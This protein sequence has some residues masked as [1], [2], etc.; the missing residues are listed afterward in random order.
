LIESQLKQIVTLQ[1]DVESSRSAN[2]FSPVEPENKKDQIIR[3]LRTTN[4][5]LLAERRQLMETVESL[6]EQSKA[7]HKNLEESLDRVNEL[8]FKVNERDD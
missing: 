4:D 3:D 7:G 6:Q 5:E 8:E 1:K 2:P